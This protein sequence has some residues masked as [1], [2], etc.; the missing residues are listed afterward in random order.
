V[1]ARYA[2]DRL[3][4]GPAPLQG[5]VVP[6][7]HER[8]LDLAM[9]DLLA[10]ESVARAMLAD[11]ALVKRITADPRRTMDGWDNI[12]RVLRAFHGRDP[13]LAVAWT[14]PTL[15]LP[16]TD[17]TGPLRL[18]CV[19]LL[20]SVT[21]RETNRILLELYRRAPADR[22]VAAYAFTALMR[23]ARLRPAAL[24]VGLAHGAAHL[25]ADAWRG[26]AEAVPQR[27]QDPDVAGAMAWWVGLTAASGPRMPEGLPLL[28]SPAWVGA[29]LALDPDL[30][31]RSGVRGRGA[32]APG[33]ITAEAMYASGWF[34][35]D[36]ATQAVFPIQGY[37][38]T[39]KQPAAEARCQLAQWGYA[40]YVHAVRADL[41]LQRD[42]PGLYLAA[43]HCMLE[44]GASGAAVARHLEAL[45]AKGPPWRGERLLELQRLLGMLGTG[46]EPAIWRARVRVLREVRPADE[47]LPALEQA[48]DGMRPHERELHDL[49]V[50]LLR[51][52]PEDAGAALRL[53]R[54]SQDPAYVPD[55][56]KR[57][58]ATH[59]PSLVRALR[60]TLLFLMA[61]GPAVPPEMLE[62]F[63]ARV[64]GWL[65]DAPPETV[66]TTASALLDL[67]KP[68][69]RA[70]A[71]GLL[72][73]RR[74]AYLAA[75]PGAHGTVPLVVAAAGIDPV[76]E[77]T[78]RAER[79]RVLALAYLTFPREADGHVDALRRRLP[80]EERG[81]ARAAL[82]RVRHR[83][84][85]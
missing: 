59:D 62:R 67:G 71:L 1:R 18:A 26:L 7:V 70:F 42:D 65:A 4:K 2:L 49:M 32:L 37:L 31:P 66:R 48:F 46:S 44:G 28:K 82:E 16:V 81:P 52:S 33:A 27:E 30:P 79:L 6:S 73:P 36:D 34:A 19:R 5:L 57:L 74:A 11:P 3:L 13:A 78:P 63:V 43:K 39:G 75:W 14:R 85:R 15:A 8:N 38:Y 72:G 41:G 53:I 29:R 84:D 50:E 60:R 21:S 23:D 80:V 22:Q 68:G 55:L 61:R 76:T 40:P 64:Q 12:L 24:D 51:G 69:A 20:A 58:D 83:A 77:E 17:E 9:A 47:A 56:E 35:V 45:L 25:W 10:M 54:R